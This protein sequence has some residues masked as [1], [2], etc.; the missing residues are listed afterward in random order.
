M[1]LLF[2]KEYDGESII[3]MERDVFE[4]VQPAFNEM[5]RSIPTDEYG[6]QRGTFRVKLEWIDD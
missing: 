3:D 4:A 6:I 1:K 5:A 2:E